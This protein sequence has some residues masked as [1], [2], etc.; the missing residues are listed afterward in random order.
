MDMLQ[1]ISESLNKTASLF[2]SNSAPL[3]SMSLPSAP[4]PLP[5]LPPSSAPSPSI[6]TRELEPLSSSW[7]NVQKFMVL[8]SQKTGKSALVIQFCQNFFIEDYGKNK[9]SLI[10]SFFLKKN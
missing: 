6:Q 3:R 8:G 1:E 7:G 2:S 4:P 10:S 5:P 9:L